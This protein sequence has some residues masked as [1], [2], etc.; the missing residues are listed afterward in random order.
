[1]SRSDPVNP[2]SPNRSIIRVRADK[3]EQQI[4]LALDQHLGPKTDASCETS[5][6][7]FIEGCIARVELNETNI[8][9][10][11]TDQTTRNVNHENVSIQWTPVSGRVYHDII[12]GSRQSGEPAVRLDLKTRASLVRAVARSRVWANRMLS[13][14]LD[15]EQIAAME[16][17]NIRSVQLMLPLAFLAPDIVTAAAEGKLPSGCGQ[18]L[19]SGVPILWENQRAMVGD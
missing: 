8:R 15:V 2:S 17:R 5:T 1:M 12:G 3:V 14:E 9:I 13:S 10:T 18:R 7:Q 4:L 6:H 11:L 16:E 19:L